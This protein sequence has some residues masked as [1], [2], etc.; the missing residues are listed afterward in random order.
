MGAK[1]PGMERPIRTAGHPHHLRE[2]GQGLGREMS[3]NHQ[4]GRDGGQG[5]TQRTEGIAPDHHGRCQ[6]EIGQFPTDILEIVFHPS[7][8]KS[9]DSRLGHPRFIDPDPDHQSKRG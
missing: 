8:R 6:E 7:D 9:P 3:Q 2:A 5:Q 1:L 4:K